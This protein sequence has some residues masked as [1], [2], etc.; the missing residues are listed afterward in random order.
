MGTVVVM[1]AVVADGNG[2]V[3]GRQYFEIKTAQQQSEK[4]TALLS[5]TE[6][7]K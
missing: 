3:E 2:N 7:K 6:Q 4:W 5:T 1:M